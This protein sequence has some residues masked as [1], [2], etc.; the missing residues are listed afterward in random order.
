MRRSIGENSYTV[1]FV[2][3]YGIFFCPGSISIARIG[4]MLWTADSE[5]KLSV[6][7]ER[8]NCCRF[9]AQKLLGLMC[10]SGE[11]CGVMQLWA[12]LNGRCHMY[13]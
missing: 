12:S 4:I 5:A 1:S 13:V 6:D 7:R 11:R 3:V 10:E 2:V 8:H 9:R